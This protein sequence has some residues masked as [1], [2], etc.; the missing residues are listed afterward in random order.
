LLRLHI[1]AGRLQTASATDAARIAA[2]IAASIASIWRA[3]Q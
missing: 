1:D 2:T 3:R